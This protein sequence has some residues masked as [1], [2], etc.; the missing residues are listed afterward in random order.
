M[1]LNSP[2]T[3]HDFIQPTHRPRRDTEQTDHNRPLTTDRSLTDRRCG[4]MRIRS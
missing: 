1:T 2:L 4:M 3:A